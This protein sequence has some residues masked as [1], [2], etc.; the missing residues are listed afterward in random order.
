MK[1]KIEANVFQD[2]PR[3]VP[4][5]DMKKRL[6]LEMYQVPD[7]QWMQTKKI[8]ENFSYQPDRILLGALNNRLVGTNI[9]DDRHI[10]T[11]AGSRSGKSVHIANNLFHYRGSCLVIDPK[12]ELAN[13]TAE[14]R[15]KELGQD[16]YILDPFEKCREGLLDYRGSFNPLSILNME[17][18]TLF[19]DAGLIAD[20]LV[21][22]SQHGDPH[23]D[24]TARNFI[25][26][27]ILHVATS[28]DLAEAR[29]LITVYELLTKNDIEKDND[30]EN[31]PL[32]SLISAMYSNAEFLRQD[33]SGKNNNIIA[34]AIDAAALEFHDKPKGE[35]GSVLSTIRRHIK[36]LGYRSIQSVLQ[37]HDFDLT[38]LKTRQNGMTIYLSL[39]AGRLGTCN[40]WLR[41]FVNLVFEAMERE[42]KKPDIPVLI[43]LDEFPVLGYMKNIEDAAGQIA[44][45]GVKLW[46]ILQDL[47]QLKSLYRERWETFMGNAGIIHFFGNNDLT[48]LEYI[49]KRLGKTALE[50]QRQSD[51]PAHLTKDNEANPSHIEHYNLITIDE[52]SRF[53]GRDDHLKRQLIIV[54]GERPMI[55]QRVE[56]YNPESPGYSAFK[57]LFDGNN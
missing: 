5:R 46:P 42:T 9:K 50:M 38:D 48:T 32:E 56:H 40:R 26:G 1:N 29:N 24:E 41:L 36:F 19:E 37:N 35:K 31:L 12:G 55:I 30:D 3:G 34:D 16:V 49:E 13:L 10:M 4:E 18:S 27:V 54:G 7:S 51:Q 11:I 20:A 6:G 17:S 45:F 53:F 2:M 23:W 25:E 52:A 14:R 8:K 21:V 22:A 15:K 47:G 44:G 39:P 57:R 33:A 28:W 43:C